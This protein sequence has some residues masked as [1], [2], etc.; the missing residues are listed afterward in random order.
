MQ[1]HSIYFLGN[2]WRNLGYFLLQRQV[3]L[4]RRVNFLFLEV[5][6]LLLKLSIDWFCIGR[7]QDY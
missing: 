5:F 3:I 7:Y 2:L 4:L 1:A 6:S